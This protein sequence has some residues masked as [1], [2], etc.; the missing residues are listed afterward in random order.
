M[1]R[2]LASSLLCFGLTSALPA[3]TVLPQMG[4]AQVAMGSVAMKHAAVSFDG[5]AL[6]VE[7][8]PTVATPVLRPLEGDDQ[9]DPAGPWAGLSEHAYNFQYGWFP[10]EFD[11]G[12]LALNEWVWIELLDATPGLEVYQRPSSA[13][14]PAPEGSP[15]LGTEGSS[16]RWRWNGAMTHNLYAVLDPTRGSYAATYRVYIGDDDS[17]GDPVARF[18]PAEV[19]FA[20][21]ATPRLLG[22]FDGNGLVDGA[23]YQVW[24]QNFGAAE[25]GLVLAGNGSGGLVDAAD[26]TLWRDN[27]GAGVAPELSVSPT[28]EPVAWPAALV[29]V[30]AGS[31]RGVKRKA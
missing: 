24:R 7:V 3:A 22:D 16:P 18:T 9:F 29:V 10:G 13:P 30:L 12:A 21:A 11:V 19:T 17:G 31:P 15:V 8:D 23:D 6:T 2:L 26:Y 25:E 28:P 14:D 5:A 20:F 1:N 4:G 27:L